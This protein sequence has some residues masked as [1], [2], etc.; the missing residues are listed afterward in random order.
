MYQ[1]NEA[2]REMWVG[3]AR[4]LHRPVVEDEAL[5]ADGPDADAL[6]TLPSSHDDVQE[7]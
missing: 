7:T 5:D 1:L 4:L 6:N 3:V 2:G